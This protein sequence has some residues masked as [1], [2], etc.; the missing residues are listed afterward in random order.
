M[1][2]IY[3]RVERGTQTFIV[4][5]HLSQEISPPAIFYGTVTPLVIYY[6]V[7]HLI[8]DPYLK[9]KEE[10]YLNFMFN[11]NLKLMFISIERLNQS[12]KN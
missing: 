11:L 12:K 2:T 5:I 10:K 4:P 8:I 9:N 1:I 3:N 6:V 7:K